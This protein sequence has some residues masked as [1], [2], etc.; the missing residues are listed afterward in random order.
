M[1]TKKSVI[2]LAAAAAVLSATST[3]MAADGVGTANASVVAAI[4]IAE[5]TQMNFGTISS[6]GTAG[7]VVLAT[8]GTATDTNVTR[9][10][11]GTLAAGAFTISGGS[12]SAYTITMPA[13]AVT[14]TSGSDTMTVSSFTHTASGTLPAATE[15]INIGATLAVGAS[16][17]AGTYAGSYTITVNYN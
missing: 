4:A 5:N 2:A 12:G 17:A 1:Y 9:L 3:A 7:T 14:L 8:G 13:S 11:G 16:Q 10:A 6:T 15:A